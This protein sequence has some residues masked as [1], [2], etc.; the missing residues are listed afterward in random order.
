MFYENL[1]SRDQ[2]ATLGNSVQGGRSSILEFFK[3]VATK[4]SPTLARFLDKYVGFLDKPF[5][6][7]EQILHSLNPK[8][9]PTAIRL[10]ADV[11]DAIVKNDPHLVLEKIGLLED[12][13]G[14]EWYKFEN[15]FNKEK[16]A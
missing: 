14:D 15:K 2:L 7:I 4:L 5:K 3:E 11:A 6:E 12:A 8:T 10:Y 16:K 1:L 13:V 9:Q